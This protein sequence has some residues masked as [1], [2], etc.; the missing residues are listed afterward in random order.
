[1]AI[2]KAIY[3]FNVICYQNIYDIFHGTRTNYPKIH[4]V[5]LKTLDCQDNLEKKE[6]AEDIMLQDSHYIT[7]PK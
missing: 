7:K 3:R 6:Q 1:M 4:M 5:P 2:L